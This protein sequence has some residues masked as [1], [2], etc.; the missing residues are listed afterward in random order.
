MEVV[1]APVI[2]DGGRLIGLLGIFNDVT[3]R[4]QGE[5]ALRKARDE[6]QTYLDVAGVMLVALDVNGQVTQINRKGCH[7]LGYGEKELVGRNWFDTCL[8]QHARAATREGF[9]GMLR[10]D[11]TVFEYFENPVLTK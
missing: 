7:V 5:E 10:G 1:K 2:D 11:T 3:E 4:V 9:G 8:P 6:A